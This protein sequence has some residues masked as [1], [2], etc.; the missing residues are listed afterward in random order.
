MTEHVHGPDCA[1]GPGTPVKLGAVGGKEPCPCGSGKKY[2]HC[3]YQ[4]DAKA[5]ATEK[6]EAV[7]GKAEVATETGDAAAESVESTGKVQAQ[8]KAPTFA[9]GPNAPPRNPPQGAAKA[10]N[11]R[12][13][14][15]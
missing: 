3:C 5:L 10:L 2:K 6:S 9:R 13:G 15:R 1:H 4:K 12:S 8:P 7:A 14:H 11:R